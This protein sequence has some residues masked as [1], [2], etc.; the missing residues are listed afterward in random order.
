MP[1]FALVDANNFYASC[2]KLFDPRLRHRPVVVLSN[3][4]GCVVARSAEAKALGIPM[5]APWFK[6]QDEARRYGIVAFSSNYALYADISNRVVEILSS[7]TP[8]LEV[9]SIDESFLEL[10]GFE[11]FGYEEYGAEIRLRVADW[12]GL[13]VCVGI[14]PTKT[15]AKLANHCAKKALA[16]SNGVCDLTAIAATEQTQLFSKIDVSEVWGVGRKLSERLEAMG[17]HSV[18]Q[19]RDADAETI[20]SKFSVVQER[21]VRELR[22]VSCLELQEIVPEKQQI[23]SSRSFGALIYD[24]EELEEA[25]ASY[26]ARAAEKLRAQDSLAGAVQVYIRTN[27]FKPEVPQYQRAVTVPLPEA[28]ADTRVLTDWALRMLRRI[29]R[30]GFGYHKA[31]ITLL[32]IVPKTNQQFSLFAAEGISQSRSPTLMQTL[33]SINARYGRGTLR[34]AAE[35]VAKAWQMRRGNLSPRYTTEWDCIPSATAR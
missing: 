1:V 13:A 24:L 4:D 30:P 11:R 34:L 22:G 19:L 12:L 2:E 18:Q 35:G 28:T 9:Y 27:V 31:G 21:T 6:L 15:L 10:S 23:M 5:G 16:G 33:D 14:G 3:N 7:F 29:Y 32:N 20:R 17:I 26:I 8:N 25:V